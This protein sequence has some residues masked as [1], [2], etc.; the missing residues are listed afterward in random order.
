MRDPETKDG[1]SGAKVALAL[2]GGVAAGAVTGAAIMYLN[3]PRSGVQSR[4][5]LQSLAGNTRDRVTRTPHA[6]R[7]ATLAAQRAFTKTLAE[8]LESS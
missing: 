8:E 6:L 3:A 4:A 7:E 2:L 1:F 5:K